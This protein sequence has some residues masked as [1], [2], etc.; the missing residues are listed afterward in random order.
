MNERERRIGENEV[1]F[2][3][4]N[5][6][7]RALD[8]LLPAAQ[9]NTYSFLCECGNAGCAE[10]IE[11]PLDDYE[12]IHADP[13]QFV[14][15]P[16]HEKPDVEDVVAERDGYSVVRKHGGGPAELASEHA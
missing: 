9:S 8:E 11:L 12:Q 2:R 6:Q 13:A 1:L 16:G 3:E 15:V 10:R 7:M 5:A 4:V 14:I